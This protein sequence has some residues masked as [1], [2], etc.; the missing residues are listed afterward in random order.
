MHVQY[1]NFN[2]YHIPATSN[3]IADALSRLCGIVAKTHH[4]P[5]DNIRLLGMSKKAAIYRKQL[6]DPLVI[7]LGIQAGMDLEYVEMV[8]HI[9]NRS[10][11]RDIP[12]QC[13]VRLIHDS[14]PRLGIC[15]LRDGNRLI[16]RNCGEVLIPKSARAEIIRTLHI[17][18]P[19]TDAMF[20]QVKNKIFGRK[21]V[22]I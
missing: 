18:H 14:I 13:E 12:L 2:P 7:Q 1:Y 11:Y 19:E 5:C 4:I 3:K 22:M 17:T 21:C 15:E 8:N 20:N 9:E 16:V 6:D 10:E